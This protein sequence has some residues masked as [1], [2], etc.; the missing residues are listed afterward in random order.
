MK[1]TIVCPGADAAGTIGIQGVPACVL[2]RFLD[3][4]R[5]YLA[6]TGVYTALVR[7]AVGLDEGRWGAVLESLHEF[8]RLYDN[9]VTVGE[10]LPRF[11]DTHPRYANLALRSLCDRMHAAMTALDLLRLGRDALGVDPQPVVTPAAAYQDLLRGR[12]HLVPLREAAGRIA[13]VI[14]APS[15]PGMALLLPGERFGAATCAIL[16]YLE[17]LEAFDRTFT[18]FE[19]DLHGIER[20]DDGTY[21]VRVVVEER[22]REA[23]SGRVPARSPRYTSHD[24][25]K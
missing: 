17:A 14:V 11:A 21:L 7:F 25:S 9:G 16:R 2:T 18:G 23:S 19:H 10:A 22:S 3:E 20:D 8:K 6:R 15:P 13:A 1:V 12:T 24:R 4:R 5:I